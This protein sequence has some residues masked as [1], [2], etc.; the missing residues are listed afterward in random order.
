MVVSA[1]T[2]AVA[3]VLFARVTMSAPD[4]AVVVRAVSGP[5]ELHAVI[6]EW[7]D[8]LER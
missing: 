7:L 6:A 3:G 5:D 4:R 1:W 2:G 8:S